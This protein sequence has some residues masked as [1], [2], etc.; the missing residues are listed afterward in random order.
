MVT[1]VEQTTT[2]TKNKTKRRESAH[3]AGTWAGRGGQV[4]ERTFQGV[5]GLGGGRGEMGA[6][7]SW[8]G[9]DRCAREHF[10]VWVAAV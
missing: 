8:G 3:F 4:W 1:G 6:H 9:V 2:T 10:K 5:G 7:I